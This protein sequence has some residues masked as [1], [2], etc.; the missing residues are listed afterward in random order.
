[1]NSLQSLYVFYGGIY[2]KNEKK[3]KSEHVL[4]LHGR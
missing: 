2:T 3:V 1:M 4:E